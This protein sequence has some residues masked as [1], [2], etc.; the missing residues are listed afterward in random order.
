MCL[1][2]SN[3]NNIINIK[4]WMDDWINNTTQTFISRENNG[5]K[6]RIHRIDISFVR[7]K[8]SSK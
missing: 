5:M 7:T 1:K 6:R 2:E 4:V 8:E 3:P